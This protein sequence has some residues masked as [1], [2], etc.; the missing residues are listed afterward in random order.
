MPYLQPQYRER[1]D[2]CDTVREYY[3]QGTESDAEDEP[4]E[5]ARAHHQVH[6]QA[7]VLR[8]T[9]SPHLH[10]LWNVRQGREYRGDESYDFGQ[11][12]RFS[13]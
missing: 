6:S 4:Q 13:F 2:Q 12:H 8:R 11:L 10:E 3:R 5:D 7:H 1:E 9:G